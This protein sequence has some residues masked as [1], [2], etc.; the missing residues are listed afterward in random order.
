[1]PKQDIDSYFEFEEGD[2]VWVAC[3][4]PYPRTITETFIDD[5]LP[6]YEFDDETWCY[7]HSVFATRQEAMEAWN[8][9]TA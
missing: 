5:D 8:E 9:H 1:M 4:D 2:E 6:A 3:K 7:A